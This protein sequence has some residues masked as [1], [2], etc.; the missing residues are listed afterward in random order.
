MPKFS[1]SFERTILSPRAS[2]SFLGWKV[3][4]FCRLSEGF[5]LEKV[6]V[7]SLIPPIYKGGGMRL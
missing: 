5:V 2:G 7:I 3:R 1:K 6:L 4:V